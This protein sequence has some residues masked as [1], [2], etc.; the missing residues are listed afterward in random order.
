MTPQ[1]KMSEK[2]GKLLA[3]IEGISDIMTVRDKKTVQ[4]QRTLAFRFESQIFEGQFDGVVAQLAER[5]VLNAKARGS[6]PLRSK[7]RSQYH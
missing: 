6:T 7:L 4:K 5:L 1:A 3:I 2:L